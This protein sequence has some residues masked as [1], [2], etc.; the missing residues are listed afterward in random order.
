[1][2]VVWYLSKDGDILRVHFLFLSQQQSICNWELL[3]ES[4]IMYKKIYV[5]QRPVRL[6]SACSQSVEGAVRCH[7]VQQRQ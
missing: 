1:M 6:V 3:G 5:T 2:N 7:S 4:N